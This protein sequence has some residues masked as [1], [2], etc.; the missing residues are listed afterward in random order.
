MFLQTHR[1]PLS[2]ARKKEGWNESNDN[3][4]DQTLELRYLLALAAA[5]ALHWQPLACF[6]FL[7]G[8][9]GGGGVLGLK[10]FRAA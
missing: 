7:G 3:T 8:G 6:A 9:G 5:P 10:G 4:W 2:S 1:K